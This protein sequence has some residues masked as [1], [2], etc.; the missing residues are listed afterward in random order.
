M[1]ESGHFPFIITILT[2]PR[3]SGKNH[4]NLREES[5]GRKGTVLLLRPRTLSF[6]LS[7]YNVSICVLVAAVLMVLT[8][9][10]FWMEPSETDRLILAA[11]GV[12]SHILFLQHL[13]RLLPANGDQTPLIG[14]KPQCHTII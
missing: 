1:E 13:G 11:V 4:D 9:M 12:L 5:Q 3:E 7:V 14:K 8:L 2:I 10:T 6:S